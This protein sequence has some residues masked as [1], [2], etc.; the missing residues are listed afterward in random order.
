MP[1]R[2]SR[3]HGTRGTSKGKRRG[4]GPLTR[5]ERKKRGHRR[6]PLGRISPAT[7]RI[8]TRRQDTEKKGKRYATLPYA[9]RVAS[10]GRTE[11]R[12]P[13]R[14]PRRRPHRSS[15]LL[16][17]PRSRPRSRGRSGRRLPGRTSRRHLRCHPRPLQTPPALL[18]E[19]APYTAAG[20]RLSG[21]RP[22]TPPAPD[23]ALGIAAPPALTPTPTA[24]PGP[25]PDTAVAAAFPSRAP[26]CHPHLLLA[27][28]P[29]SRHPRR[30]LNPEVAAV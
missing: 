27:S 24:S 26:C 18:S 19:T 13:G 6:R 10:R 14:A 9:A 4:A 29:G 21:P 1:R 30:F 23:T 3:S 16:Q 8:R 15:R 2:G 17:T 5:R 22:S 20:R 11:C 7:W 28:A 12:L 25:L